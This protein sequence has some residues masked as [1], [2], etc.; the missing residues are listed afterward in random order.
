MISRLSAAAAF[1]AVCATAATLAYA[2]EHPG[3]TVVAQKAQVIGSG[4]IV[5]P[6]VEVIGK[7]AR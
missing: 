5:L 3:R 4:V 6:R 7:R 2:T 1:F